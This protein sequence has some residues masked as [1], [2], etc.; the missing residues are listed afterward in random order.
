[1][2]KKLY[3]LMN[4]AGDAGA[5]AGGAATP[6]AAPAAPAGA[7]YDNFQ[8]PGV[9]DWLKAYGD[10]YPNPEAV[11]TKALN[12]EKFI[13][14]DKAGRGVVLPKPDAKPEEWGEFYKK[15]GGVPEKPDGYKLPEDMVADPMA[16]KFRDHAHA[17]GMPPTMFD[18]VVK[19]YGEQ[20]N[21]SASSVISQFEQAAD[22]DMADLKSEW[23]GVE[24]D[25][26]VELGRRAARQFIPHGNPAEL[27][28]TITKI[29]G[30]IGTKATMK[31]LASIGN[32]LGEHDFVPGEGGGSMVG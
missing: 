32:S 8:D 17:A 28:E 22:R 1:M 11:A 14:A 21:S 30:A 18:A 23:Q 12:L 2:N 27:A 3:V 4:Q 15:V 7:W 26:N 6:D 13:G 20:M 25:K 24:F 19:W 10:A 16:A 5:A 9:K 31:M 29:E